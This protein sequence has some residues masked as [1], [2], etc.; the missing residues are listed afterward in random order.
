[1]VLSNRDGQSYYLGII[2]QK[3]EKASG[4][5]GTYHIEALEVAFCVL[6]DKRNLCGA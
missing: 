6:Q 4:T 3:T 2:E 1:M 5:T